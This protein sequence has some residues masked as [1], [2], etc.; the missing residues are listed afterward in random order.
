MEK[1]FDQLEYDEQVSLIETNSVFVNSIFYFNVLSKFI[2]Q[3]QDEDWYVEFFKKAMNAFYEDNKDCL[4]D[5]L[6]YIEYMEFRTFM[7]KISYFFIRG[8]EHGNFSISDKLN[9]CNVPSY[10]FRYYKLDYYPRTGFRD[11]ESGGFII[12]RTDSKVLPINL[13]YN[14]NYNNFNILYAALFLNDKELIKIALDKGIVD[15]Q[16]ISLKEP[17][18]FRTF[19]YNY[20]HNL[21]HYF[22]WRDI[23]FKQRLEEY[24][25]SI[26]PKQIDSTHST[27]RHPN[28]PS[29]NGIFNILTGEVVRP[30]DDTYYIDDFRP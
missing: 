21:S 5:I 17:Y 12:L 23:S 10:Q 15:C 4:S 7:Y 1:D 19:D 25:E 6:Q 8:L 14:L 9:L 2:H 27:N 3:I 29:S 11:T 20:S 18:I 13:N 30:R 24:Y 28:V 22:F 26:K 16:E